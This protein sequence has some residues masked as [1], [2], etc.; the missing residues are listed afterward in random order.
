MFRAPGRRLFEFGD[1]APHLLRERQAL[2]QYRH[3][4]EIPK[5]ERRGPITVGGVH[6]SGAPGATPVQ[7]FAAGFDLRIPLLKFSATT[8]S[9]GRCEWRAARIEK[10]IN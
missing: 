6:A 3:E 8:S 7:S 2:P 4:M 9:K 5:S 10:V 1:G